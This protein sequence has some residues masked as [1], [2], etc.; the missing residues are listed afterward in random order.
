M[1]RPTTRPRLLVGSLAALAISASL[2][3]A[4]D[5]VPGEDRA[6]EASGA[7][8]SADAEP[9]SDPGRLRLVVGKDSDRVPVSRLVRV[10][11]VGGTVDRVTVTSSEGDLPGKVH[12]NG[13]AWKATERL[14]PGVTYA[15]EARGTTPQG[16]P[17]TL[18]RTFTAQALTL[19]EQTYA[20]VAPLE[21][22]TVGVGMPVVVNFDVPVTD[23]ARFERHMLVRT[24][25]QQAGSWHWLSDNIAHWRPKEYWKPGT[26]VSVD[27]DVNGVDAGNGIYGQQDRRVSFRVGDAHVYKVD[28][29][30]HRME[31]YSNGSRL[32]TLPIT[33]GKPGFTTR[34]GVK[35]IMAKHRTKRMSSETIGIDHDAAEGYDLDDVEYA[36]RLTNSGEFIHAAP[37]SVGSQGNAN[38]SHGCTGL[39]TE[40]AGWLYRMSR[41]G[42]VVEYVGTDR[43]M[44]A[45]NG[46]GDWNVPFGDYREGS[47]LS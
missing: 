31:V 40:N 9:S 45:D 5:A 6:D 47:A 19:A 35:V 38:V 41:R 13:G 23:R 29:A 22:E 10:K 33:A 27:L 4:C 17:L 42:D 30:A 15:V 20:S 32:R 16:D 7:E 28:V 14:E 44:T 43:P 24:S 39:S 18:E 46:Y 11:A 3:S 34:S 8:G 26:E 36:M 12:G 25:P 21:G 37:W 2:L 1:S